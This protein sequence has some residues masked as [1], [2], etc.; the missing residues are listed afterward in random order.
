ML[1]KINNLNYEIDNHVFFKNFNLEVASGEYVSIIAPNGSGKTML[2]KLM[3]AVIPTNDMFILDDVSLN[4]ENVLKYITKIG[5]VSNEFNN[6]CLCNKVKDELKL[7]LKNLGMCEYKINRKIR[8][9]GKKFEINNILNSN[10]SDL[11]DSTKSKLLIIIS[12]IHNPKLLVLDDAF[13]NMNIY[14]KNFML[15]KLNELNEHGLTII[16][17]TSKLDT[18]YDS[19]KVIVMKD[20]KLDNTGTLDEILKNESY[21]KKIGLEIPPIIELSNNLK[22]YQLLDQTYFSTSELEKKL[23]K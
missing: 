9:F 2:T 3:C 21:L 4:K 18:I 1:F 6:K 19:S 14:D 22:A 17:I 15:S 23:W 8:E 10:I 12:L 11:S 7:P 5:I 13:N 16:N 20:F